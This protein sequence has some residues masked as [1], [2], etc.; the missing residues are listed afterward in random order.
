MIG[1]MTKKDIVALSYITFLSIASVIYGFSIIPSPASEH[2]IATDHKRVVDL[3][4]IQSA[5]DNYYQTN[6]TLPPTLDVLTTQAYDGSTPLAKTDPQTKQPYEYSVTGQYS[7]ELCATFTTDSNKEKPNP[8][9]T[10]VP[11]YSSYKDQFNHPIGHY[12]FTESEQTTDSPSPVEV[13]P[14]RLPCTAGKMC[15]MMPVGEPS[16]ALY[17]NQY[18]VTPTPAPGGVGGGSAQ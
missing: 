16:P 15:P 7:Y 6:N 17:N 5:V 3:A 4:N 18:G 1:N 12:C 10:T 2:V 11:D 9:D 13:Y 8:D 14:S